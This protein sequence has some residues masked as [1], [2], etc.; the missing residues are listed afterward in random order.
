MGRSQGTQHMGLI[1]N[2]QSLDTDA[3]LWSL[4][5]DKAG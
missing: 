1:G 3:Q 5:D 2:T 4:V